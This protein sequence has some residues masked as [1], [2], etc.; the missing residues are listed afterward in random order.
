MSGV[1]TI[2]ASLYPKPQTK[3]PEKPSTQPANV[4]PNRA[5]PNNMASSI[6]SDGGLNFLRSRLEE[7]L[8]SMFDEVAKNSDLPE[9]MTAASFYDMDIDVSPKATAERI[10][11][12]ALNMMG[13]YRRQNQDMS[14]QELRAGFEVEIR[15][16]I[17][18]GFDHAKGV[19]GDLDLLEGQV[20]EN[21]ISTWDHVQKMLDDYF[22]DEA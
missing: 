11:G 18:D 20:D 3:Q 16:G 6:M 9:G 19:L 7:K 22:L 5:K 14:E 13:T 1:T 21:V 12:F 2:T 15:K 8:D 10:V 4:L 17:S